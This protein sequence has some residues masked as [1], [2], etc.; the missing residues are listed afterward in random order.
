MRNISAT[1]N[2]DGVPTKVVVR[3][4]PRER[5]FEVVVNGQLSQYGISDEDEELIFLEGS[6]LLPTVFLHIQRIIAQYFP[7][8]RAIDKL[9]H[10]SYS[11]YDDY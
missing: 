8:T 11:N 2:L 6:A 4:K 1:L 7:K 9:N 5:R 3:K 10:D